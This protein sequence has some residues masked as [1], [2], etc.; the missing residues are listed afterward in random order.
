M[1]GISLSSSR[2][3]VGVTV[4]ATIHLFSTCHPT[5]FANHQM[6][7]PRSVLLKSRSI[8]PSSSNRIAFSSRSRTTQG[9][10]LASFH[11]HTSNRDSLRFQTWRRRAPDHLYK[12][13]PI[14][15]AAVIKAPSTR[16]HSYETSWN[17]ELPESS[18]GRRRSRSKSI[19]LCELKNIP[20]LH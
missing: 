16:S 7:K 9:V 11:R 6:M 10:R 19:W 14:R 2:I 15:I 8:W 12:V 20:P 5:K 13:R 1:I 4:P 3:V 17:I 18:N